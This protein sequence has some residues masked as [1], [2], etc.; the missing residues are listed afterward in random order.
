M[1]KWLIGAIVGGIITFAWQTLS[2]TVLELHRDANRYTPKQDSILQYLNSQFTES[3][4]YFLPTHPDGASA[5]EQEK[6]M[7][8]ATGKPWVKIAYHTGWNENMGANILRGFIVNILMV[9][10]LMWILMKIPNA[11]FQTIF[12]GSLFVGLIGFMHFP[13]ST[14]IWYN[15]GGIR[16]DLL[17]AVVMWGGCGI[18]LGWW[19]R[20]R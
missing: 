13:Y 16:A 12:L 4:E 17:D 5:E 6:L 15:T 18:W 3:G 10:L 9:A 2:W 8:E 1:K 11:S 14:F 7:Q 19:L 20:K